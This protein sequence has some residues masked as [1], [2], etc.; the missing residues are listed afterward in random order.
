[1]ATG[2]D[3]FLQGKKIIVAGA[4]V[5]GAAFVTALYKLWDPAL[6]P[7]EVIVYDRDTRESTLAREGYSLSLHG[8]DKDGGLVAVQQ[9]GMLDEILDA[10]VLG[11][12]SGKF[13]MWDSNWRELIAVRPKPFGDLPSPSVRI[14]RRDLRR[15]LVE[16]AEKT[17]ANIHWGASCTAARRHEDGRIQVTI[18]GEDGQVT[19]QE[20]DLLIAADG[21]RSKVRA[22][23]RPD[24]NLQSAGAVQ[25]GGSAYFP[26]G[27]PSPLNEDWGLLVSGDGVCCFV[28]AVDKEHVVWALSKREEPRGG[29]R[30]GMTPEEFSEFK[31]EALELGASFGE[32]FR[33]IVE[34]TDA[35][36]AIVLPAYDKAP[37]SHDMTLQGVVFLGDANHAV[38]PFAGN[39]ANLALKDG[40][41]LAEKLCKASGLQPAVAAYDKVSLRR[42]VSTLKSSHQRISLGHCTG[43]KYMLFMAG[44]AAGRFFMSITGQ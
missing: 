7:P 34:A 15:I 16:A 2:N 8:V 6:K 35:S 32:Q 20:C 3:H 10:S 19:E 22:S 5:A 41:D 39:G 18:S 21:A 26:Q 33:T 37:F 30:R 11:I 36:T 23:F 14:A 31:N 25:L 27:I 43:F 4:G 24:D 9:L 1:M 44:L 29:P 13:K 12:N 28:S 40:W 38:S 42:A 17:P